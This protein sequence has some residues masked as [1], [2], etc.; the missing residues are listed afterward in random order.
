MR[1]TTMHRRP[2]EQQPITGALNVVLG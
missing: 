1:H 2:F